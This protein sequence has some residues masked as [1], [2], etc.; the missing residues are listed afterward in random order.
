MITLDPESHVYRNEE[1]REIRPSATGLLKFAGHIDDTH[2]T[3]YGRDRGRLVHLVARLHNEGDLDES[4]VDPVLVPYYRAY[5]KWLI[6]QRVTVIRSEFIA[7]NP[8]L[9]IVCTPDLEAVIDS[10]Q[11]KTLVELK[12]GKMMPWTALQLAFQRLAVNEYRNRIGL[13]LR[14]NGTYKMQWYGDRSDEG[15]ILEDLR[16]YREW[17]KEELCRP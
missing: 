7:Y 1:G 3:E 12:S 5:L 17:E 10:H 14:A 8:T 13:E 11:T 16:K 4:T 9:G 6:D 2:Y 15:V